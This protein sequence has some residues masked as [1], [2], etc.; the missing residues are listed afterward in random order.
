MSRRLA[1]ILLLAIL[2]A[3]CQ[4]TST[5]APA[6]A[7]TTIGVTLEASATP[8]EPPIPPDIQSQMD[9]L[10]AAGLTG[11]EYR[12]GRIYASDGAP[13]RVDS[14]S[15]ITTLSETGLSWW[16]SETGKWMVVNP[17]DPETYPTIYLEHWNSLAIREPVTEPTAED[18]AFNGF[19]IETYRGFFPSIQSTLAEDPLWQAF[20]EANGQDFAAMTSD[21]IYQASLLY[22]QTSHEIIMPI[23]L[24]EQQNQAKPDNWKF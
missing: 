13:L 14:L 3:A 4:P 15:V 19:Q 2:L 21:Q 23:V 11:N 6:A 17:I 24:L 9:Q 5:P 20:F 8:T 18:I 1:P 22:G 12:D 7:P 10:A 16:N